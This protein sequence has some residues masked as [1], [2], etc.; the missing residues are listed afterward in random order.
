MFKTEHMEIRKS[1]SEFQAQMLVQKLT[2]CK[3]ITY[4]NLKPYRLL[5]LKNQK[6]H[7]LFAI[8]ILILRT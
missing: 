6:K 3:C 8:T 2:P 7:N 5:R 4:S 1:K